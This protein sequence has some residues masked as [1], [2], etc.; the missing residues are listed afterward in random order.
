MNRFTLPVACSVLGAVVAVLLA[1]IA[2]AATGL[3][4]ITV[5]DGFTVTL[6]ASSESL[7]PFVLSAQKDVG[8]SAK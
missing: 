6:A 5:P 1:P 2:S 7:G 4:S 3:D 8:A